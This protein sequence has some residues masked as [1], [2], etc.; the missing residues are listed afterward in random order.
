MV[1]VRQALTLEL[2]VNNKV[3]K[4]VVVLKHGYVSNFGRRLMI[5]KPV[6]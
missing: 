4:T 3:H 1:D 2:C 6:L 5:V